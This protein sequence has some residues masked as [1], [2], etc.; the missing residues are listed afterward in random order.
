MK[1][2][3][4]NYMINSGGMAMFLL[5]SLAHC[6]LSVISK[7]NDYNLLKAIDEVKVCETSFNLLGIKLRK[8]YLLIFV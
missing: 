5:F 4:I 6:S 1:V 2:L 8:Y 7:Y 3:L